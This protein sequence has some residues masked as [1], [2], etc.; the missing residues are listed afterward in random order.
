MKCVLDVPL[1]L[2]GVFGQELVH[3]LK[4]N[5]IGVGLVP[6]PFSPLLCMTLPLSA[7]LIV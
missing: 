1:G 6:I 5:L 7:R 4:V 3:L 2:L